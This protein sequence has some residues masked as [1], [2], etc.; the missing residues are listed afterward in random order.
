MNEIKK[1][2]EENNINE[3]KSY[4]LF[5]NIKLNKVYNENTQPTFDALLYAIENK[6][7]LD[8]IDYIISDYGNDVN[9]ELNFTQIPLYKAIELE[10]FSISNFLLQKNANINYVSQNG[11]NLLIHLFC[12]GQLNMKILNYVMK[13]G[14]NIN[15]EDEHGKQFL[16]YIIINKNEK[17]LRPVIRNYIYD[18]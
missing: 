16:E 15:F 11:L 4:T 1:L 18:V 2:I 13:H 7:N 6:A 9:Y 10:Y 8:I 5:N 17:Y 12:S 3:L 14:I